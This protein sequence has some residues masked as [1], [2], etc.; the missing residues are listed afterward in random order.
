MDSI[1]EAIKGL[2]DSILACLTRFLEMLGDIFD[3]ISFGD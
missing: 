3:D 1:I 2:L